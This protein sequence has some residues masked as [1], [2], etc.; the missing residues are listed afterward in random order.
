VIGNDVMGLTV[1]LWFLA[2]A[3]IEGFNTWT[4]RW[5]AERLAPERRVRSVGR[6]VGSFMLR[7]I[8]TAAVLAL[9]FRHSLVS[10]VLA[11]LGYYVCRTVLTWRLARHLDRR[12]GRGRPL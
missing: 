11:W 1:G 6:F 4:R 8:L 5:A 10:G 3:A 9:A 7:V 12:P 2:G